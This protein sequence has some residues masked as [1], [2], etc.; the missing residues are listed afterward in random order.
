MQ[1]TFR[2]LLDELDTE[3]TTEANSKTE[4]SVETGKI[5][6]RDLNEELNAEDEISNITDEINWDWINGD[7]E[8]GIQ[9]DNRG[10]QSWPNQ[11]NQCN[12]THRFTN[13]YARRTRY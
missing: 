4:A 3:A 1:S 12:A 2:N 5:I 6:P 10:T 11:V 9:D 7:E 13:Y 8:E